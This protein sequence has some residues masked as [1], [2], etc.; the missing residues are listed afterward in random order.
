ML[1]STLKVAYAPGF[2]LSAVGGALALVADGRSPLWLIPLL[3]V[4]IVASL[5]AE[6][7][8]PYN[9]DFNRPQGDTARDL[10]HALV[11]EGVFVS[12]VLVL[13]LAAL[14]LPDTGLW[15]SAWPLP[16]QLAIAIV[17]ADF[18]ITLAHLASHKWPF[19]WRFHAVHHSVTRMYGF[20]GLLKHPIHQFI[21]MT[22]AATPLI[23]LGIPQEVAYLLA[24]ATSIQLLLQHS[25]VDIEVGILARVWAVAPVHRLH[26]VNSATEGD[27]NFGLFTT[28]WDY[29]LCTYRSNPGLRL[30][31]KN[32]GLADVS[33]YPT[34]YLGHLLEPFRLSRRDP[35]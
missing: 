18:G 16:L 14:L 22:A 34:S 30:G 23:I 11:N 32:I 21:E 1:R 7:V 9:P 35:A 24:F 26:H 17:I 27:C 33:S 12:G 2:F 29:L 10:L 31:S 4:C 25:N 15:P 19:L 28:V 20:N 8:A 13:P 3:I 5:A 6:R